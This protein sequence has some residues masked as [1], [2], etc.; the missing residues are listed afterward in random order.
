MLRHNPEQESQM[1][2]SRTASRSPSILPGVLELTNAFFRQ[3][4]PQVRAE[5]AL[6]LTAQRGW[7]PRT[8]LPRLPGTH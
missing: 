8:G 2:R 5:L 6:F 1:T 3:A 4:S 7:N